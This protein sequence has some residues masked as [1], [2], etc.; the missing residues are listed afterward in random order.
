MRKRKLGREREKREIER[1]ERKKRTDREEIDTEE[2]QSEQWLAVYNG[3]RANSS[4]RDTKKERT[5]NSELKR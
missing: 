1:G 3:R 5:E 4:F 2:R